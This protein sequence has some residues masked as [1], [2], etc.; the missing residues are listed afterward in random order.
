M[1]LAP[2][3]R[4][5]LRRAT[6]WSAELAKIR[7]ELATDP[8]SAERTFDVASATEYCDPDRSRAL[9]LYLGACRGGHKAARGPARR[10]GGLLGA[11]MALAELAL[12]EGELSLAGIAYID[13]G[14]PALAV[15]PLEKFVK[16]RPPGASPTTETLRLEGV[17]G[18]LAIARGQRF[19]ADREIA[20]TLTRARHATGAAAVAAYIHAVRIARTTHL[21]DRVAAILTTAMRACP[22]DDTIAS[23]V[24]ARLFETN[25]IDELLAHYSARL[26]LTRSRAQYT[27]R[28]RAAGCELIARNLQP[29]LG[30]RL[31]RMSL[32]HAYAALLPDI[33]SHIA[34]WEMLWTHAQ[35]QHSTAELRPLIDQALRAPLPE[36]DA[37]YLAQLGLEVAWH[38]CSDPIAAKPYAAIVLDF[39]S[40]HPVA[41]AFVLA[42][43]PEMAAESTRPVTTPTVTTPIAAPP[44]TTTSRS[45]VLEGQ[46]KRVAAAPSASQPSRGITGRMAL[47]QPPAPPSPMRV[48]PPPT[49]PPR[50]S[51]KVVPIDVVIELPG[52][53]FF[54]T[55]LRDLSTSGAFIITKRQLEI[56]TIVTLEM[57]FP[58]AGIVTQSSHRTNARVARRTDLGCGFAFVDASPLLVAAI[59]VLIA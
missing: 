39:V 13:A 40:D 35:A 19:D 37:L 56:G 48:S 5:R 34:V 30:L 54:S 36:D 50:A 6:S 14:F 27:E 44:V 45:P 21:E 12:A 24:E 18:L 43:A 31:L 22:D 46:V 42:A 2:W 23:L 51:R 4:D 38:H 49:Y 9:S 29:G 7:Q 17:I 53:G 15:E 11:H 3:V 52:G 20:D 8:R 28:A 57:R 32:E 1:A 41:V 55:V 10:L 59:E 47:L 25:N 16:A 58:A 26:E 33:T